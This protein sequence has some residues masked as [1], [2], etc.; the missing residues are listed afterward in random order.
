MELAERSWTAVRDDPPAVGLLP[1]GSVEQHGPHA[2]LGTDLAIAT[3]VAKRAAVS[4]ASMAVAPAIPIGHAVEHRRFAG[5]LWV[6]PDTLRAYVREVATS[7]ASHGVEVVVLVNGH[8]GNVAALEEVAA[9]LTR[10]GTCTSVAFTWFDSLVDPPE[11]MGHGGPLETA[12]LLAI[13]PDLVSEDRIE[14][15]AEG[16][17]DRWG[18]W[19]GNTNLAVDVDAFSDNGVVGDPTAATAELGEA[20]LAEAANHLRSVATALT[21]GTDHSD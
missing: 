8:G 17:A 19:V 11:P 21:E 13:D 18:E 6:A 5:S 16:A 14:A 1:V 12:A 20:L 2:P 15:A 3:A 4:D 9:D 7:L 10:G